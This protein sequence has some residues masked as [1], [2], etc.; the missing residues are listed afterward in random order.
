MSEIEQ[1]RAENAKLRE[2]LLTLEQQNVGHV[3]RIKTYEDLKGVYSNIVSYLNSEKSS[4]VGSEIRDDD[5]SKFKWAN[6]EKVQEDS[7]KFWG[8]GQRVDKTQDRTG[9]G[10]FR[11]PEFIQTVN[12][13]R[14]DSQIG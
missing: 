3:K 13:K 9:N 7:S 14:W 10:E 1:L 8:E 12:W 4:I 6:Q 2:Q 5:V 11:D